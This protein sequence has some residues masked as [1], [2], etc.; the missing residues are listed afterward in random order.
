[1]DRAALLDLV[2]QLHSHLGVEVGVFWQFLTMGSNGGPI[3]VR[4]ASLP[5]HYQV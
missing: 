1:M 5:D 3:G 4:E 2:E